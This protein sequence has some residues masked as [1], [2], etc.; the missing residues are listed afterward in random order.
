MTYHS[1]VDV[2]VVAAIVLAIG[3]FLLGDYWIAGPILLVLMLCAYPQSYQT[4][5]AGLVIRTALSKVMIPYHAIRYVGPASEEPETFVF[6][7]DRVRIAYGPGSD[8]LIDPVNRGDFF[9]DIAKHAPHLMKRGQKLT[10]V[11]A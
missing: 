7:S 8:I 4:T 9:A 10:T 1:K 6:E 2:Y 5:A 3:V 11:F